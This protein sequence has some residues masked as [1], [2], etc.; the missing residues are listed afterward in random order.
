MSIT[1]ATV[2][3]YSTTQNGALTAII[4][5][6]LM[7]CTFLPSNRIPCLKNVLNKMKLFTEQV[8]AVLPL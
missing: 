5:K 6:A 4:F 8:D 2:I 3:M 7:F 1:H